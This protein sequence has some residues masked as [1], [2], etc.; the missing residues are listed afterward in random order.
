MSITDNILIAHI[1]YMQYTGATITGTGTWPLPTSNLITN[2]LGEIGRV[3]QLTTDLAVD[4]GSSRATK[5]LAL[6]KHNFTDKATWRVRAS[7][8]VNLLTD[9]TA[10]PLN[11]IIYDSAS[12]VNTT[13][14]TSIDVLNPPASI[15]VSTNLN[16]YP[17]VKI[18]IIDETTTKYLDATVVLYDA[19]TEQL[20]F[21]KDAGSAGAFTGT[22]WTIRR[23]PTNELI[24]PLSAGYGASAWGDFQ[25]DGDEDI[26]IN[27]L[28]TVRPPALLVFPNGG[29]TAR[30]FHISLADLTNTKTYLDISKII[31][32]PGWQ[33]SV[34]VEKNWS[35][36]LVDK[37]K[38]TFSKG[39]QLYVDS[40]PQYKEISV[41]FSNL[42]KTEMMQNLAE[43]DRQLGS[44]IPMLVVLDPS[45]IANLSTL[46]IYGSQTNL[47]P[48]IEPYKD[49]T[50][51]TLV[52]QEWI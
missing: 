16:F 38:R 45:N 44:G 13:S 10:V 51:K 32:S 1:D 12:L 52:I 30:Y 18:E 17:G 28:F 19:T 37:S 40:V 21:T 3:L 22:N 36:K 33:P 46:S 48:I 2:D 39:S 15:R 41:T 50:K 23:L 24:W 9:P 47:T 25:W 27:S 11:E 26:F 42:D 4:L 5:V 8:N 14:S 34:N 29:I 31:V 7:D 43:V 49:L 6:P 35:I 20:Y